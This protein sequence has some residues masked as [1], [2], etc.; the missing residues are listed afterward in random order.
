MPIVI[1]S[2]TN[3]ANLT[4]LPTI[5]GSVVI[6]D[7]LANYYNIFVASSVNTYNSVNTY[8][9]TTPTLTCMGV[10]GNSRTFFNVPNSIWNGL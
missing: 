3:Y 6:D 8:F 4:N 5:Q 2:D 7:H 10:D 9:S 1:P